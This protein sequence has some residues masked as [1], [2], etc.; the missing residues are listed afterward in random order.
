MAQIVGVHGIAQ[1]QLGPNQLVAKWRP[2]LHDGLLQA[3]SSLGSPPELEVA[4]YGDLFLAKA[5][6]GVEFKS[7]LTNA[8]APSPEDLAF[9]EEALTELSHELPDRVNDK[10]GFTRLPEWARPLASRMARKLDAG[11][12]LLL[13]NELTQVRRY[14]ADDDLAEQIHDV[15]QAR[16]GDNCRTLIGHSL[17]SVIAH[18]V[19]GLRAGHDVHTLLTLGSPLSMRTV[20]VR[21]RSARRD[22]PVRALK[23]VNV[24]DPRD[25]VACAGPIGRIHQGVTD[26]EVSNGKAAHAVERYLGKSVCGRAVMDSLT[27]AT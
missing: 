19:L 8:L 2:A 18:E 26:Y 1:E 23:W 13:A 15:V 9:L 14:L 10:G 4:F 22:A 17:G 6:Q 7:G 27:S 11:A 21:L 25:P 20:V 3:G 5:A 24:L 12:V 16:I